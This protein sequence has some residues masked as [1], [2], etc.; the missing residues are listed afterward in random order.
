MLGTGDALHSGEG[1]T[2]TSTV[3]PGATCPSVRRLSRT[4]AAS[5]ERAGV[6]AAPSSHGATAAT[7]ATSCC[8]RTTWRGGTPVTVGPQAVVVLAHEVIN[9]SSVFQDVLIDEVA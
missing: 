3:R 4:A 2:R 5:S 9:F 6:S 8:G 1:G 7:A